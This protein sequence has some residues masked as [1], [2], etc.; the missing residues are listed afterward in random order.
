MVCEVGICPYTLYWFDGMDSLDTLL[1]QL[2]KIPFTHQIQSID[3]VME[4]IHAQW[5]MVH[6]NIYANGKKQWSQSRKGSG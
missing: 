3:I 6:V 5:W 4:G 2:Q 1:N